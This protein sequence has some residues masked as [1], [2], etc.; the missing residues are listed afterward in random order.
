VLKLFVLVEELDRNVA[1]LFLQDGC[2][3]LV[4]GLDLVDD[5]IVAS[6]IDLFMTSS[7]FGGLGEVR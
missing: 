2:A 6:A 3:T 4:Q 1:I 7:T 5:Y